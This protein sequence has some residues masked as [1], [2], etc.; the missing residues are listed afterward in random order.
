MTLPAIDPQPIVDIILFA[1]DTDNGNFDAGDNAVYFIVNW[2]GGGVLNMSGNDT[3]LEENLWKRDGG[4]G[5]NMDGDLVKN[6]EFCINFTGEKTAGAVGNYTIEFSIPLNSGDDQDFAIWEPLGVGYGFNFT[7]M[8]H[9]GNDDMDFFMDHL[10]TSLAFLDTDG[11]GYGDIWEDD[12]GTDKNSNAE[13][14]LDTDHDGLPDA[15]DHDADNDGY[16]NDDEIAG[17][18]DPKD[19]GSQPADLDG[20]GI[21]DMHDLD[22]DG[23]SFFDVFEE[24]KGT[25]PMDSSSHPWIDVPKMINDSLG[26]LREQQLQDGSWSGNVGITALCLLAFLNSNIEEGDGA[27]DAAVAYLLGAINL[28]WDANTSPIGDRHRSTY[29]VSL[30][31]LALKATHNKAYDTHI[32]SLGKWLVQTQWNEDNLWGGTTKTN[33]IYGGWGYGDGDSNWADLSNTQWALM[34]LDAWGKVSLSYFSPTW[35]CMNATVFLLNCTNS[36]DGG[37]TYKPGDGGQ[38]YGSMTAAALWCSLLLELGHYPGPEQYAFYNAQY[39]FEY[40]YTWEENPNWGD[41][42]LYYYYLTLAKA[43]TMLRYK[44]FYV[45][46]EKCYYASKGWHMWKD[47][48]IEN[49]TAKRVLGQ[50]YWKG[51]SFDEDNPELATAYALLCLQTQTLPPGANLSAVFTLH[52]NA[53]LHIYDDEG[54]HV[55]LVEGLDKVEVGI[56][57]ATFEYMGT[58]YSYSPTLQD[59]VPGEDGELQIVLPLTEAG[60]YTAEL[61]GISTGGYELEIEGFIDGEGMGAE[62]YSGEIAPGEVHSTDIVITAMEGPLTIFSAQPQEAPALGLAPAAV[63]GEAKPGDLFTKEITFTE[64]SGA[65]P[66]EG[67]VL[68]TSEL[69]SPCGMKIIPAVNVTV[70]QVS[71]D[72]AGGGTRTVILNVDIP[73]NQADRIYSGFVKVDMKIINRSEIR[74][75][76]VCLEVSSATYDFI[77]S[78]SENAKDIEPGKTASYSILVTNLANGPDVLDLA[79]GT[80]PANWT[81]TLSDTSLSLTEGGTGTVILN[82]TAP[83]NANDGDVL[84]A[85]ITVTS[86]NLQTLQKTLDFNTTVKITPANITPVEFTLGPFNYDDGTPID[87]ATVVFVN[88]VP[89][90]NLTASGQTLTGTTNATG[91][92]S[93]KA[94]PGMLRG[95][96]TK[97]SI[98]VGF[99]IT[100]KALY[101]GSTLTVSSLST[102]W[103]A[104]M[105]PVEKQ[106]VKVGPINDVDGNPVAGANVLFVCM[107]IPYA[108]KTDESGYATFELPL[109]ASLDNIEM[110][111]TK[112]KN[113]ITW[114]HG[115]DIPQL[116]EKEDEETANGTWIIIA[117]VAVVI[118]LILLLVIIGQRKKGAESKPPM[119]KEKVERPKKGKGEEEVWDEGGPSLD[120]DDGW[121]DYDDDYDD[122]DYGDEEDEFID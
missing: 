110:T 92:V 24:L 66:V 28:N 52:S 37:F 58:L 17:G 51:N 10:W 31:L 89:P 14:P 42:A 18:S 105:K 106:T 111:A 103:V 5:F 1:F 19:A 59:L 95:E 74:H 87:G 47:D 48:M 121:D 34:A 122:E 6:G 98:K 100:I 62:A 90:E 71:F 76:P 20:D 84:T 13:H 79:V 26:W 109:N 38:S 30:T 15:Y 112:D 45:G 9:D 72:L 73:D 77:L 114:S 12:L 57:G 63:V 64:T 68:T 118:I 102:D 16:S 117:I 99:N 107:D 69:V 70:D 81:A 104:P 7:M 23:D 32:D 75:I 8:M 67:I 65:G 56:P 3:Y 11:D 22:K 78:S 120:D 36:M 29:F 119:E 108:A 96:L 97:G 25:D 82:V 115:D 41:S 40:N 94:L 55:G 60:A 61:V 49:I 83:S 91:M 2:T 4:F 116:G 46:T 113:S 33:P 93:L 86:R 53:T 54:R 50:P 80:P 39:W 27:V 35:T 101:E 21:I 43:F 44:K 88:A 85:T